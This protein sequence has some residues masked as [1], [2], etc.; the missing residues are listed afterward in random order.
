MLAAHLLFV[1]AF[2]SSSLDFLPA[3]TLDSA[4]TA[5]FHEAVAQ[6]RSRALCKV[7]YSRH[8]GAHRSADR[9]MGSLLVAPLADRRVPVAAGFRLHLDGASQLPFLMDSRLRASSLPDDLQCAVARAFALGDALPDTRLRLLHL[10]NQTCERLR[11]VSRRINLLMPPT[12][13]KIAGRIN[14]ACIAAH[15]D[16][17]AWLDISLVERLVM[18]F[19]IVGPI[20]DSGV[21]RPIASVDAATA[22]LRYSEWIA[23][24]HGWNARLA[25]RISDRQW[26]SPDSLAPD[27]AVATKTEKELSKGVL[28]GPYLSVSALSDALDV[29]PRLMGRFGVRQK[30]DIRTIDDGKANGANKA[31]TL[32]ETVTTPHFFFPAVVARAFAVVSSAAAA[33]VPQMVV[34]LL[35][36]AM[37]YRTI[38][39]SQPWYTAFGFYNPNSNRSNFYWLPGHNFGLASAVVN[40]NRYPELVSVVA[41]ALYA[42]PSEHYYDDFINPDLAVA[43]S[44]GQQTIERIMLMFASGRPRPAGTRVQAPELDAGKTQPPAPSNTVL[45][46]VTDLSHLSGPSPRV[47]F[48]V[49]PERIRL[50]LEEFHIAFLRGTLTPHEASRLRGKLFFLLSAAF[51]N[52]GRA[53]TLPLVQRQYRDKPPFAF[54]RGSELFHC[55]DFFRTLLPRLPSLSI[56]VTEDARTPP[57]LIY[58]D[59]SFSTRSGKRTRDGECTSPAHRRLRGALGA[60][61]YDP[62]D[63]SV[64][65]ASATPPWALL[66]SSWSAD[67]KTYIAELEM[68]AAVSVY[69]TYPSL[70]RGRRVHHFIDNTVA[71]SALVHGYAGKPDL[72][73]SVN[74]FYLQ[75]LELRSSV[76]FDYVPSKAN[77]ADLPSRDAWAQLDGEL[78]GIRRTHPTRDSLVVPSVASWHAPLA[79]WLSAPHAAHAHMPT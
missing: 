24:A 10:H 44:T 63:H 78:S 4:A 6:M 27:R 48:Y 3:G 26:A 66:L 37:A 73:K 41:R 20:P 46:V 45:G 69:S 30:G 17:L 2:H 23:G 9:P 71:L 75:M 35:D 25:S 56:R 7:T 55:Y 60:V 51:A 31:T 39:V 76:Y 34:S 16:A 21:Y 5:S 64:R 59:A 49:D 54:A 14:T 22:S 72:A 74:V 1:T 36:L 29:Y 28:V 67:R 62:V 52:V 43:G 38:P 77:I 32:V 65:V 12:V 61:V 68:L 15:V 42:L 50:V 8:G 47:E 79:A 18:G 33:P 40:F 19:P 53:A 57:L 70:I 11:P 13:R 58:T